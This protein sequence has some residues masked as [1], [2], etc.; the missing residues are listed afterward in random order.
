MGECLLIGG[1][2]YFGGNKMF[3][4]LIW[5]HKAIVYFKMVNFI[6]ILPQ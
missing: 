2:V 6:K 4:N 5:V 3:W 1:G